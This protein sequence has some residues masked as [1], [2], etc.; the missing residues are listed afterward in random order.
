M[1]MS[2]K[3]YNPQKIFTSKE[4]SEIFHNI[5]K[6]KNPVLET[7]SN[8]E[9]QKFERAQGRCL[10]STVSGITRSRPSQSTLDKIFLLQN[11]VKNLNYQ[12]F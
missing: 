8:A 3:S 11:K 10:P 12:Y 7:I 2:Q 4:F 1:E 5:S 6:A 9:V